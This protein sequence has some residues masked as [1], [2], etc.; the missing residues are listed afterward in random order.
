MAADDKARQEFVLHGAKHVLD[1]AE[2]VKQGQDREGVEGC[3]FAKVAYTLA[4]DRSAV[5][6]DIGHQELVDVFYNRS[7]NMVIGY[8]FDGGLHLD[9]AQLLQ[10]HLLLQNIKRLS[11]MDKGKKTHLR[12]LPY[13]Q[14]PYAHHAVGGYKCAFLRAG[15]TYYHPLRG[16]EDACTALGLE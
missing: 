11:E 9:V 16:A 2:Y 12:S 6:V 10:G 1:D 14:H 5:V 3:T 13:R 7:L 4:I 15:R 8:P